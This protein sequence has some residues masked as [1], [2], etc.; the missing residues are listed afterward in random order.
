MQVK[1][2]TF[3]SVFEKSNCGEQYG[4]STE[5]LEKRINS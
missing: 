3:I 1:F 4:K 2:Y 5:N